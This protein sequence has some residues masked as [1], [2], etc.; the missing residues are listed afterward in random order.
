MSVKEVF[1]LDLMKFS[2]ALELSEQ[3]LASPRLFRL[4]S[5]SCLSSFSL[6]IKSLFIT[7]MF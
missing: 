6:P 3:V 2:M 5:F 1:P 7:F 4:Y